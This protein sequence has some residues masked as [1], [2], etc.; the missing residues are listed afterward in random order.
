MLQYLQ[1]NFEL[2]WGPARDLSIDEKTVGF[3]GSHND[4]L[5]ITFKDAGDGSQDDSVFD[6][7]YT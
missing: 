2:Y 3:Q 6:C 7:G 1:R 5:W 4:K